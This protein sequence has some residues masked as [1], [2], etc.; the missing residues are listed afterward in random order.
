MIKLLII[1]SCG[2]YQ[3]IRTTWCITEWFSSSK[4][5]CKQ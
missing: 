5:P 4:I 3:F 2:N 1:W